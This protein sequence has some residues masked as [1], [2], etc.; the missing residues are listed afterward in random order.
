LNGERVQL[1]DQLLAE[2]ELSVE[3]YWATIE[4]RLDWPLTQGLNLAHECC[5][6]WAADRSRIALS[7]HEPDGT[8]T[9]WTYFELME[10]SRA[11]ANAFTAA[12]LRRGDRIAAVLDQ[13]VE[14]YICA[15][16]VWRAGLVYVPLF[17]GFGVD[18]LAQ[19]IDSAEA[20]VVVVDHRH[21]AAYAKVQAGLLSKP[22]V[23]TVSGARGQGIMTGDTSVWQE[24]DSHSSGFDTVSTA[25]TEC[26]TLIYTSGTTGN[27]KGC[28]HPHSLLLPLQ[29]FLRHA[30][31]LGRDDMFFAGANPGWSFG[32]YTAGL[33]VQSLGVGRV[34]YTGAF[35]P[36]AWLKV[37]AREH[38]TYVASAPSAYRSLIATAARSGLPTGIRGGLSA[39]EP[40][41]TSLAT[42]W[43]DLGGGALQDGYGSSEM[44]MVLANLAFDDRQAPA[45]ALSSVVPGFDVVLADENGNTQD[46]EGIIGVRNARWPIIGYK[47]L[48][49]AWR[50]RTV[51][52]VFLSGDMARRD[53]QGY[54]WFAGRHDDV[55]VTAGYNVG[56]AEVEDVIAAVPGVREVAVV[57]APDDARGSVV[58]AVVVD[59]GSVPRTVLSGDIQRVAKERLGRHAYPKII[60]FVEALPRTEVGKVR[61]NVL[62][63]TAS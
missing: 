10:T 3:Q 15:L 54:Y 5:D 60:D 36:G 41:T 51:N 34:I 48:E 18:A 8:V 23:W 55:I 13:Q 33:G 37:M 25:P 1:R 58:R 20:A 24:I 2:R 47:D 45:G 57:A 6:R 56:P 21:R 27:P 49:S 4:Q 17:V 12:G 22:A 26:A 9:R 40:L 38:V 46:T 19:R 31:A 50:S 42:A 63:E 11:L 43:A 29:S 62:R 16:A 52:G 35:D 14:A 30:M 44:G 28:L 59:D 39:G 32:L 7:V 53:E 61:R